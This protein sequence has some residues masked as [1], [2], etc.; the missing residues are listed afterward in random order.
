MYFNKY[1][2]QIIRKLIRTRCVS[3]LKYM[4]FLWEYQPKGFGHVCHAQGCN[5]P[6]SAEKRK[7]CR[8]LGRKSRS[9]SETPT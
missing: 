9:K 3:L 4:P 2:R 6:D 5:S 8:P 1:N 7:H